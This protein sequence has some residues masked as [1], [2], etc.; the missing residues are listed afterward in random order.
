MDVDKIKKNNKWD[1][2]KGDYSKS[3][4]SYERNLE[5]K[6]QIRNKLLTILYIV[7]LITSV[8]I[9]YLNI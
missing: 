8:V 6:K 5:R 7:I 2:L 1:P 3:Y 4:I 9:V